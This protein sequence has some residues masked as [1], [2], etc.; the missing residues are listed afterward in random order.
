MSFSYF[1]I[2]IFECSLFYLLIIRLLKD[3]PNKKI[4]QEKNVIFS[5]FHSKTTFQHLL[6]DDWVLIFWS[7]SIKPKK[8]GPFKNESNDFWK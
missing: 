8:C 5:Y 2:K 3:I 4:F 1:S 6:M 7:F